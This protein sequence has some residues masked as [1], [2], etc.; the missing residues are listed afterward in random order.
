MDDA[1][2]KKVAKVLDTLPNGFPSTESGVEIKLLK[3]VFT[4]EQAD[5][6]CDLRLTFETVEEIAKRT[7]RP[8]EGLE[9]MLIS[10]AK[11]GQLFMIKLEATRYFK[12]LPWVFGLYEFQL[13]RLDRE[14]AEL[15]TVSAKKNRDLWA[16]HATDPCRCVSPSLRSRGFSKFPSGSG[17]LQE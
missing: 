15:N 13:G 8:M 10:M 6:F 5:L 14:F 3:K 12:M 4:R 9:E 16:D 11:S 2:Y 1:I 7:G 17:H